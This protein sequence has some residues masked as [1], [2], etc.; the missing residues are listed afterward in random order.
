MS[1]NETI[2][3]DGNKILADATVS[4]I[5]DA[6]KTGWEKS[7]KYFKDLDA[8]DSID[9]GIAY[10]RYLDNTYAKNSRIKTLI[11]RRVPKDLYSFYE[12]IGVL[13]ENQRIDTCDIRN[14]LNISSKLIITG[15]GGIG[16]SI[17][18][19]HLF[20]NTIENTD[21]IP[22]LIE[23]RKFNNIDL[24]DISLFDA[25]YASLS[26][27]GFE[28]KN[29]YY[30]YSLEKGGYVILL[31]G[32]DEVK[33]EKVSKVSEQIKS[34]SAKYNKN[35]FIIS[36]RPTDSFIGWNDF[37]EMSACSLTKEQA[38]SL[39]QKIEFDES[40]KATFYDALANGLFEKY[41]SFASNP[42]LLT[43]MLL[44][45]NDHALIPENL[46][47]F[48]E[49]AFATLFNMHDATKDCYV[50]D[51]RSRL[52]CED[53]KIIFAYICFKSYFKGDFEFSD[54]K[55]REYI[56]MAKDK[57]DK[58]VFTI[59]EFQEDLTLSVCMLIKDG[60]N[61]RFTH[62]SFQEYFA[63]LYTCKLTDDVQSKLLTSWL[64]ESNHS[65]S[66]EYMDMLY[67]LQPDK[68]N[69]VVL[70]PGIKVIKNYYEELGIS[71]EFLN[72]LFKG[73]VI[74]ERSY[75]NNKSQEIDRFYTLSLRVRDKYLCNILRFTC[76]LNGYSFQNPK[77]EESIEYLARKIGE[78]DKELLRH[79]KLPFEKVLNIVS[80]DELIA[81]I[82]W[83]DNQLQFIF[84]IYE[85]YN[86]NPA[87]RKRKVS[88]I[89]DE[90]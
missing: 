87:L 88:S 30:S 41:K 2:G 17:L 45:F 64:T 44:T 59:D 73:I 46:N 85:K 10:S 82:P 8:K 38:L 3:I 55:L 56:Q 35:K 63:A 75:L 60:L 11:Y 50:R 49:E 61:Y 31:D 27:N 42:L 90:L 21:Y 25:I 18:F 58:T 19:K 51:I 68:V 40:V 81:C 65:S 66:D 48:Y 52:G 37:H 24:K 70:S 29:E 84:G 74:I 62:R 78:T 79:N 7:K 33:K 26:E 16:K 34:F 4:L 5:T 36:S 80:F 9:Y 76:A 39:I 22:V 47:D 72:K 28:L 54:A 12:C 1:A 53:F 71:Y 83:L 32:F 67:N 20:V 77:A 6:I 86:D 89:I 69:K 14:L 23:L 15:T 57:F 13:Y 43:I